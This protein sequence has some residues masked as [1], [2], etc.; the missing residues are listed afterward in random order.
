MA[1]ALGWSGPWIVHAYYNAS[2]TRGYGLELDVSVTPNIEGLLDPIMAVKLFANAGKFLGVC[3]QTTA[4]GYIGPV[5]LL[6]PCL[7]IADTTI[8][9]GEV[10]QCKAADG[11]FTDYAA[12][13]E[14]GRACVA[15]PGSGLALKLA[16]INGFGK[17]GFGGT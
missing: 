6:G 7:V 12:G 15:G 5:A 14:H 10:I 9:A 2:V 3:Q 4:A 13:D 8:A 17:F 11:T 16:V 1:T